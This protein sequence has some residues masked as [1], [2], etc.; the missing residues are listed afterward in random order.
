MRD[1]DTAIILPYGGKRP[2]IPDSAYVAPGAVIVGD[3]ALGEQASVW[4]NCTV[5]GD[6]HYIRIGARTNIQ[7]N[8]ILHVTKGTHPLVI[9]DRVTVGHGV[10]LHG[11]TVEDECLVGIGA[12]VLDG[13]VIESGSMVA[14]G[15][16]VPPGMVVRTGT[17]VAGVPA[18]VLR[19]IREQE[20]ENLPASA[21]RYVE[22]AKE[23]R[24]GTPSVT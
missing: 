8:S 24:T 14:A 5:R 22:Y 12:I 1:G 23:M 20:R 13:A 6:I 21:A 17:L 18:K 4:F 15:A 9:G 10:T 7:D 3:V 16:L 19:P 2:T 11:C